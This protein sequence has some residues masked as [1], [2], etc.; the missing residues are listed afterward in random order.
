[1]RTLGG[2]GGELGVTHHRESVCSGF[3]LG[4]GGLDAFGRRQCG[5]VL[6]EQGLVVV[7]GGF[8]VVGLPVGFIFG[9]C[10]TASEDGRHEEGGDCDE[11]FTSRHRV[12]PRV[13]V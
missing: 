2:Q 5:A 12:S 9:G 6:L 1:M 10:A 3:T 7:G 4:G 13:R 8:G 11:G